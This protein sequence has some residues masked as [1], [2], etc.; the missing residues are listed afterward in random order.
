MASA[1][2]RRNKIQGEFVVAL[3]LLVMAALFVSI[4]LELV[5]SGEMLLVMAAPVDGADEF[6]SEL[7]PVD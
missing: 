4:A 5:F 7:S 1:K 3:A 2:I 6:V